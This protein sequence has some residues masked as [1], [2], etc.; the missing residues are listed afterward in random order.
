MTGCQKAGLM[1]PQWIPQVMVDPGTLPTT[2]PKNPSSPGGAMKKFLNAV[3]FFVLTVY[4]AGTAEE[5]ENLG[6]GL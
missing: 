5:I 2:C 4:S 6:S 3:F 1:L